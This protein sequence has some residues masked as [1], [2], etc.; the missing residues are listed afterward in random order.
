MIDKKTI[1]KVKDYFYEEVFS[2]AGKFDATADG[3]EVFDCIQIK[4]AIEV[5]IEY[6][7]DVLKNMW[8]THL[9][10]EKPED[11]TDIVYVDNNHEVW[12]EEDYYSDKYDNNTEKGWKAF[13]ADHNVERW[14]Y[15][16]DLLTLGEIEE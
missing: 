16:K 10:I 4:E 6:I 9:E 15:K 7:M 3:Y 13:I 2:W 12:S 5:G 1:E 14:C 8:Y 11:H